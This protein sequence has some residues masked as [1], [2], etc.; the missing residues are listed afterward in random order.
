[1]LPHTVALIAVANYLYK[2]GKADKFEVEVSGGRTQTYTIKKSGNTFNSSRSGEAWS[3]NAKIY[4]SGSKVTIHPHDHKLETKIQEVFYINN[5]EI[6]SGV[7]SG[8]SKARRN[9]SFKG[10]I[11]EN[12]RVVKIPSNPAGKSYTATIQSPSI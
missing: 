11:K 6:E 2:G 12:G 9:G 10:E 5:N 8:A 4:F 3:C 1:M 7:V